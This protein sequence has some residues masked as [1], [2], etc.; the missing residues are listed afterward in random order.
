M[1]D[2]LNDAFKLM[3]TLKDA[4]SPFH[5]VRNAEEKLRFEG[6]EELNPEDSWSLKRGGKYYVDIYGTTLFAFTVGEQFDISKGVRISAAHTDWPCLRVKPSPEIINNGYAALNVEVYGGPILNTWLDRP[7]SIAGRVTVKGDNPFSPRYVLVDFKRSILT[8]PNLP[9]H[10]NKEVNKGIELNKQ[11]DLAPI[12][13]M[14]SDELEKDSF[15]IKLLGEEAKV[16][17]EDIIFFDL[18]IYNTDASHFLGMNTE[19]ISS[20]RLDNTTGVEACIN[21]ILESDNSDTLNIAVLFDNEEIGNRTKQG[22]DSAIT[23]IILERIMESLGVSREEYL[24]SIFRSTMLSVDVAHGMH[25]CHPEKYDVTT[26]A[27]LNEG[28]VIKTNSNQSYVT[29][30]ASIGIVKAICENNDIPYQMYANR[31]DAAGGST[32]GSVASAFTAIKAV[33]VGVPILA[34]HSA[35]ELMGAK[36]MAALNEL[37]INFFNTK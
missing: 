34:M 1:R 20:P 27:L 28:L 29:D 3:V 17:P 21:G 18:Y 31:S 6:F 11:T 32:L 33:D 30:G 16:D 26:K 15:F 14:V 37:V 36:D 12:L 2:R 13:G 19:F 10:L 22:A 5:T 8:I 7:L 9:I 4:T 35:R 25:P 24:S 23:N